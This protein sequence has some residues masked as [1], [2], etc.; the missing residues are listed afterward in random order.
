VS[1][2]RLF[3]TAVTP[4]ERS[5]EKA[6][7]SEYERSLPTRVMSVPW[8]VVI[9]RGTRVGFPELTRICL[10]RNAAVACGTA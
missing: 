5:I 8:R 3:D 2:R 7:V 1:S 6:T 10:A 9:T 4:S